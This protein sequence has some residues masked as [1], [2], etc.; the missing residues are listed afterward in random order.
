LTVPDLPRHMLMTMCA[1]V[2]TAMGGKDRTV[3]IDS[4]TEVPEDL[5]V[6]LLSAAEEAKTRGL[7]NLTYSEEIKVFPSGKH[8]VGRYHLVRSDLELEAKESVRLSR[9]SR[10]KRFLSRRSQELPSRFDESLACDHL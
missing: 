5:F 4:L 10:V 9:R 7:H 3:P 1:A 2:E 6:A 8:I